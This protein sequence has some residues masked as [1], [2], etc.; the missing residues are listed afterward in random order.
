[1]LWVSIKNFMAGFSKECCV[2]KKDFDQILIRDP[3][4]DPVCTFSGRDFLS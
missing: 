4:Q 2:V 1:M 3:T